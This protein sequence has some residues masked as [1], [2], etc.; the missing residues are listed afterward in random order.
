[1]VDEELAQAGGGPRL[2]GRELEATLLFSDVRGFTTFSEQT[3]AARV[4]EILNRYLTEM[5]DAVTSHG[6]VLTTYMG[7]GI[8]AL[9]GAPIEYPDHAD[10]AMAAALEMLDVRLPRFNAWLAEQGIEPFRI[11]VGINSGPVI[12]GNVGSEQRLEFTA[13]GD[14]TNTASRLE[15]MTK[16]TPYSIFISDRTCA[17]LTNSPCSLIGDLTIRGRA[18]SVRVWG[19][20]QQQGDEEVISREPVVGRTESTFGMTITLNEDSL[21]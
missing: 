1:V 21:R 4:I 6:G 14:A 16:G 19:Y 8:M 10:R 3:P 13:I 2:G 15:S 12:V 17:L 5:T 11:G 18:T 9:F 20:P 7:D